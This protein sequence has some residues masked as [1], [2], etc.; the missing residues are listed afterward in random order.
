MLAEEHRRRQHVDEHAVERHAAGQRQRQEAQVAAERDIAAQQVRH[1]ERLT[2]VGMQRLRQPAVVG[3]PQQRAETGQHPEDRMPG[4]VHDE[5][6]ADDRRHRRRDAEPDRHLRHHPLRVGR[7]EHVADDG[8]RDHHAGA[9]RQPLHEAEEDQL[10][11]RLRQR[12]AGRG[13]GEDGDAPQ[14]HRPAADAVGDRAV[15]QVHQCEAGEVAR[16]RLL[17]LDRRRAERAGDARERRQ[18]GVD[19]ER[20]EHRQA[21]EQQRQRPARGAPERGGI[22]IHG[23]GECRSG[24]RRLCSR[25]AL[26]ILGRPPAAAEPVPSAGGDRATG[27]QGDRAARRHGGAMGQQDATAACRGARRW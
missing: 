23:A 24:L 2:L 16:Q 7:R 10:A 15:E 26:P 8:P 22:G 3:R 1:A 21:G 9:R 20:P 4:A 19:R 17:H 13:E 5:Q 6:P 18:V 27:Q 11:D 12:A 14:D 25:P